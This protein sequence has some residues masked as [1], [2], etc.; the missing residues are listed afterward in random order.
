MDT[1]GANV[2][3]SLI[4]FDC[5]QENLRILEGMTVPIIDSNLTSVADIAQAQKLETNRSVCFYADVKAGKFEIT[6]AEAELM[7]HKP[8]PHRRPNSDVIVPWANGKNVTQRAPDLWIIDFGIDTKLELA[9]KYEEPFRIVKERVFPERKNVKRKRYRE[10]WWL[11]AEPC[12]SMR[13]NLDPID[14]YC[15]TVAVSKHRLFVWMRAPTL[16][17]HALMVYAR[18]DDAFFGI[19]QCRI[20]ENWALSLGTRLETP[21]IHA[22]YMF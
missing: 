6:V 12:S 2:H 3:V 1:Y 13:R 8:N 16:P 17:D 7:L 19:L 9:S 10:L 4:G 5:G 15:A 21:K 22:N 18:A 20:H 14:R 11:H